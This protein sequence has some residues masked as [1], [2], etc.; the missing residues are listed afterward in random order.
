MREK[1]IMRHDMYVCVN[2]QVNGSDLRN[3]THDQAVD[4]IRHA[5]SPVHFLVQSLSTPPG[6]CISR[7]LYM[8]V[9]VCAGITI[10]VIF[11]CN[12]NQICRVKYAFRCL[13]KEV[14]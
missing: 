10:C 9:C 6:V 7:Y 4:V 5:T 8:Y 12:G 1:L 13:L 14:I 11:G 2:G 3:A